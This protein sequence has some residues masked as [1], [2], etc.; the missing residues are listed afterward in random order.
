MKTRNRGELSSEQKAYVHRVLRDPALFAEH[1]LGVRLWDGQVEMLRSIKTHRRT[2]IKACHGVGKTFALAVGGL[3]WLAR[4]PEGIV[5]TTS[6]TLRQVRTQVWSEIHRLVA[7]SKIPYPEIRS[8]ELKLRGDE[9]YA[10]GLSTNEAENFQGYHGK[11]VLI[12]ADEA[13]GIESG[14]CG[15]QWPAPWPA[16][17]CTL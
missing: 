1:I 5:L 7:R 4:Y 17:R 3:W 2:A 6:P 8:T 11:F 13:P 16:A 10:L 9:N 12:I 15:T 14:L